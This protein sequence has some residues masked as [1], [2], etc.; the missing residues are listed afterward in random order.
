MGSNCKMQRHTEKLTAN[1]KADNSSNK[2]SMLACRNNYIKYQRETEDEY[3]AHT[4]HPGDAKTKN[5]AK[6]QNHGCSK[7]AGRPRAAQ[8]Q[9]YAPTTAGQQSRAAS[10]TATLRRM[11]PQHGTQQ[12]FSWFFVSK[13]P[14]SS[15][16]I[17]TL[18]M[19]RFS[20][21]ESRDAGDDARAINR[22][23]LSHHVPLTKQSRPSWN[24][25]PK[26]PFSTRTM[27]PPGSCS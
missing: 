21:S 24:Q 22:P 23:P 8:Q 3:T 26:P 12:K 11:P 7:S 15:W 25:V 17:E 20:R 9:K 27:K 16:R 18:Y 14:V 6:I 4:P 1:S 19:Y 10:S 5:S 13:M 2:Y